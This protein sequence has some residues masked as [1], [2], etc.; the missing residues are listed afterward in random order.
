[1]MPIIR[2]CLISWFASDFSGCRRTGDLPA[3]SVGTARATLCSAN[4]S[5]SGGDSGRMTF[6]MTGP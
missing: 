2:R 4:I 1:M 5:A 6:E 3:H